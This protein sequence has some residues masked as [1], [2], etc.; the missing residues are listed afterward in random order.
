MTIVTLEHDWLSE[1]SKTFLD[2]LAVCGKKIGYINFRQ[3]CW[4]PDII[5]TLSMVKDRMRDIE[6]V[7]LDG[8]IDDYT[9]DFTEKRLRLFQEANI[10]AIV[11]SGCLQ[12][13]SSPKDKIFYCPYF[14]LQTQSTM[15]DLKETIFPSKKY[16]FSS[17]NG[18]SRLHRLILADHMKDKPYL[19]R[20]CLTFNDI[21]MPSYVSLWQEKNLWWMDYE[22]RDER[23]KQ[24]LD[25]ART[26]LPWSNHEI[27]TYRRND[28]SNLNPA[29]ND[30]YVNIITETNV[31]EIF[32]S[33]KTFKALG[34]GQFFISINA[35]GSIEMLKFF[36]FDVF[37]DV[38][39]H[40]YDTISD[41][42]EKIAK[43]SNL[44]DH[45]EKLDWEKL[46]L[47]TKDRRRKNVETF[48]STSHKKLTTRF[49]E[50]IKNNLSTE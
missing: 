45:L 26:F 43:I 47:Q 49:D 25:R 44:L 40:E 46:W 8:S 29:Y 36:G 20:C 41:P 42:Y 3:L 31:R 11:L 33:E 18:V 39:D 7:I 14:W 19:D 9:E 22:F 27:D 16:L 50:F 5:T 4:E 28:H 30:C 15:V 32:F 17:L 35:P 48:F 23:S 1:T 2:P 37:E 21:S 34:S 6:L 10:N 24:L 13:L 12:Y 38:I